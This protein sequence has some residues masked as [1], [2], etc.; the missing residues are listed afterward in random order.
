MRIVALA[1][2][3]PLNFTNSTF[4]VTATSHPDF[5]LGD[6]HEFNGYAPMTGGAVAARCLN[7]TVQ[8]YVAAFGPKDS[9]SQGARNISATIQTSSGALVHFDG[10]AVCD[11]SPYAH[12]YCDPIVWRVPAIVQ[13]SAADHPPPPPRPPSRGCELQ[14]NHSACDPKTCVWCADGMHSLCFDITNPPPAGSWKCEQAGS[15]SR[16]R[17]R[18]SSAPAANICGS[19]SIIGEAVL[20]AVNL[21]WHTCD[22]DPTTHVC[23]L[24]C[25]RSTRVLVAGLASRRW[26]G[27]TRRATSVRPLLCTLLAACALQQHPGETSR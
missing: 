20:A 8:P 4:R 6:V 13:L 17:D 24:P 22:L 21:S 12:F 25:S 3:S 7:G 23:S 15:G 18:A 16:K 11:E 5:G 1:Q 9:F 2:P 10:F 19:N 26:Q 27:T 14:H